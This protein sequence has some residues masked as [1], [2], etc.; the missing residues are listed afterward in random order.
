MTKTTGH[1]DKLNTKLLISLLNQHVDKIDFYLQLIPYSTQNGA[2]R[3]RSIVDKSGFKGGKLVNKI[4]HFSLT[5]ILFV[6][7]LVN[8]KYGVL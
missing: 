8:I 4:N 5:P 1:S 2:Y 3:P 7:T 6:L